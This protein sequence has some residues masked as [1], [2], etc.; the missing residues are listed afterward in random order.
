[1]IQLPRIISTTFS[2]KFPRED[3]EEFPWLSQH[4]R[5]YQLIRLINS[6]EFASAYEAYACDSNGIVTSTVKL[7]VKIPKITPEKTKKYS[8][9][10]INL[11]L[12][13]IQ[14]KSI[15]EHSHIRSRLANCNCK[16]FA[17]PIIDIAVDYDGEFVLT[18][19]V[20]PFLTSAVDLDTWLLNKGY[21]ETRA[22]RNTEGKLTDGWTGILGT[23]AKTKWAL[24]ALCIARSIELLHRRR[25]THGDI[26]P[27]NVF[28]TSEGPL[29]SILI[30]F[31]EA[32]PAI[33]D[34]NWR[35]R[36]PRS[37]LAPERSG[38][39]F[40]LNEQVDVYS[41]GMLLFYLASGIEKEIPLDS[42]PRDRR[43]HV[44]EAV[45][46]ANP[47]LAKS[48]PRLLDLIGRS[49]ARDP[50][51]RPRMI[52]ICEDL[53]SILEE[54]SQ[55]PREQPKSLSDTLQSLARRCESLNGD[56]GPVLSRLI[57]RQVRELEYVF[58]GLETEMVQLIGTRDQL[59]R[60]LISLLE[61]LKPGDSW[62]T[63]TTLSVWQ[64]SALGVEGSYT[65]ATIRAVKRKAAV[66]RTF[67]VSIE[68]LGREFAVRLMDLLQASNILVLKDLAARFDLS[69]KDYDRT[70]PKGKHAKADAG[71]ISWHRERFVALLHGIHD[72]I[73][74]W[75]LRELIC[76]DNTIDIIE[77][78]GLFIGLCIV[79]TRDDAGAI[80]EDNPASLMHFADAKIAERKWLLVVTDMRSKV[81]KSS[82]TIGYS[83]SKL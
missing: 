9:R 46:D 49:T 70:R 3:I 41:F 35:M 74:T 14:Q 52:D 26:H 11:R 18:A 71:A 37:Y 10:Q 12:E 68:E 83:I 76:S 15:T 62:T 69:I 21:R 50:A 6:G 53:E 48:D 2:L 67:I 1:M 39:R 23:T 58:D 30:D 38:P 63:S 33:P 59:L 31:G 45:S 27:G 22:V 16:T 60:T 79:A 24:T 82:L 47:G 40:P 66:R 32:F 7:V 28:M 34:N 73:E 13:Y 42:E 43:S 29:L 78:T 5:N 64:G 25:V 19:T 20:Q 81:F 61:N 75:G 51:D 65:S 80:R 17:N 56:H 4:I 57:E 8:K 72:M 77:S 55:V 54:G 36:N 44:Y